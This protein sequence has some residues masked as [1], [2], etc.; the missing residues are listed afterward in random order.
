M[1]L[2]GKV[3][4]VVVFLDLNDKAQKMLFSSVYAVATCNYCGGPCSGPGESCPNCD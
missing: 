2:I 1:N 3:G 4:G